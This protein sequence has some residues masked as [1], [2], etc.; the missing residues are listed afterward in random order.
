MKVFHVSV[1]Y[2][3]VDYLTYDSYSDF[4]V[5]CETEEQARNIHPG[6]ASHWDKFRDWVKTSD[7]PFL[8]VVEI[9]TAHPDITPGTIICSSYHAG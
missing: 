5:V 4:V 7:I 3:R 2:K 6:D 8:T 9:G 1:D